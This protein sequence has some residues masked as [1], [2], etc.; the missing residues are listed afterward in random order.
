V[1]TQN[2]TNA[3]K[4][5]KKKENTPKKTHKKTYSYAI[6]PDFTTKKKKKQN[7]YKKTPNLPRIKKILHLVS[8]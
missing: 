3:H 2:T 5:T 4:T 7:E 8:I 6:L 1:T